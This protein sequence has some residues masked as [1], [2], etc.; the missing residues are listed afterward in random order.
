MDVS[1]LFPEVGQHA[2]DIAFIR[3]DREGDD[4]RRWLCRDQAADRG[5]AMRL[6][7]VAQHHVRCRLVQRGYRFVSGSVHAGHLDGAL[8]HQAVRQTFAEQ[9]HVAHD[10]DTRG[11]APG[12]WLGRGRSGCCRSVWKRS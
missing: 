11:V 4:A 5:E 7:D 10:D 12:R 1:D 6:R 9:T 3:C 2:D 8:A